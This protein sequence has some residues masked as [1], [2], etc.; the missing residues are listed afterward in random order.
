MDLVTFT[1]HDTVDGCLE[2]LS[3]KGD[4]PD[5][6]MSEEVSTRDPRTGSRLHVSIYGIDERIHRE[7]QRLRGDVRELLAFLEKE[8]VPVTLN[9]IGSS[10]VGGR[11]PALSLLEL[12]GS[13]PLLET[14]N[15]A[16]GTA[17]NRL[18]SRLAEQLEQTGVRVGRTGGS[19]AHT[20]RRIG[21][22]WTE[23]RAEDRASYLEALCTRR[24]VPRGD[25]ARFAPIA[26]DVYQIVFAYYGDVV[27]NR[28][29]HFTGSDWNKAR[30]SALL[31]LP[32]QLVALPALGTFLRQ[33]RVRLTAKRYDREM[34]TAIPAFSRILDSGAV[35][36]DLTHPA[37][38]PLPVVP[39]VAWATRTGSEEM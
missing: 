3:Q 32:L 6:F 18:A 1:D 31:S 28:R 37:K 8:R 5:F 15:G 25:S 22:A 23:A 33:R 38:A 21:W 26:K 11:I 36:K 17:S 30:I 13:F 4:L 39:A 24:S 12:A 16:Q 27:A 2:L 9:H 35:P 29:G 19:D 34:E 20:T 10:L 7:S 14:Q